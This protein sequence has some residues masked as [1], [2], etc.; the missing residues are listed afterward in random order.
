MNKQIV[1]FL[2]FKGKNIVYLS[3]NGTYWIA[4][5]PVCEALNIEYTR[6]YKN[7]RSDEILRP[8]LAKQPILLPGDTQPRRFVCLPEKFIYGWI[9]SIRSDSKELKEYKIECYNVLYNHFHGIITRRRILIKEKADTNV[10]R[11][12]VEHILLQNSDYMEFTKLKGQERSIVRKLKEL[13]QSE[14]DEE[15]G[16]FHQKNEKHENQNKSV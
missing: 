6:Q 2:E 8:R 13:E 14:I 10:K 3:E 5:K 1:K 9:F 11:R 4:V 16:L 7:L 15:L 12:K